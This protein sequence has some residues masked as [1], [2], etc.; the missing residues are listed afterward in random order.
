MDIGFAALG[1]EKSGSDGILFTKRT[2]VV[3]W[4]SAYQ[5]RGTVSWNHVAKRIRGTEHAYMLYQGCPC[6]NLAGV[7]FIETRDAEGGLE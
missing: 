6:V 5:I 7:D 1:Q 2:L 3:A 4:A